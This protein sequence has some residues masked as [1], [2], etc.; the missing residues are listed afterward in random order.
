MS[1]RLAAAPLALH[2][3]AAVL[4]LY[5]DDSIVCCCVAS[6]FLLIL[7]CCIRRKSRLR[8]S[9]RRLSRWQCS[10]HSRRQLHTKAYCG[11]VS[12]AC[13]CGSV[14]CSILTVVELDRSRDASNSAARLPTVWFFNPPRP[15][16]ETN[17]EDLFA[18]QCVHARCVRSSL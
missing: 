16:A 3:Y 12:M 6:L 7:L 9:C 14:A 10:L 18:K 11:H 1:W 15:R 2:L 17:S 8:Y 13:L 5:F 4:H